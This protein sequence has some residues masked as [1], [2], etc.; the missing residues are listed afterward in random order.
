[1]ICELHRLRIVA[2]RRNGSDGTKDLLI[3]GGHA[4]QHAVEHRGCEESAIASAAGDELR[5][6]RD[7]FGNHAINVSR[8][9]FVDQGS[10]LYFG[11]E[12]IADFQFLRM[13]RE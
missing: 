12:G 1:M 2:K 3:E 10:Q 6:A 9:P 5:A 8:L 4:W 7:R 13:S 11:G